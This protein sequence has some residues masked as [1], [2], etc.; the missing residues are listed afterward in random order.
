[1]AFLLVDAD[2]N[3]REVLAIG[4]RLDGHAVVTAAEPGEALQR[5][6]LGGIDCCV[7]DSNV[8][9]G[10]ELLEAA[11]RAGVRLVVTGVHPT[12]LASAV[13]RHPAAEMLPKPFRAGELLV[14][15]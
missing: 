7:V 4:L 14:D 15:R 3:F 1:M 9:G 8:A 13:R 5:L 6:A 11:G 2:R 10:E 12:L